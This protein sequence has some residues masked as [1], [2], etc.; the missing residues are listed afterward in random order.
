MKHIIIK[1]GDRLA[2]TVTVLKFINIIARHFKV[3][4]SKNIIMHN[5]I[6]LL[7]Y[8]FNYKTLIFNKV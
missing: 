7:I 5:N 6:I 2:I 4:Y 1:F 8:L 3:Y